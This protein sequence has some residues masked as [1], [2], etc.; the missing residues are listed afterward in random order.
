MGAMIISESRVMLRA[1]R[2]VEAEPFSDL[3]IDA[4]TKRCRH[5]YAGR[6]WRLA[7][8]IEPGSWDSP[9]C[10]FPPPVA[11][12]QHESFC[13]DQL[14]GQP[15]L[16]ELTRQTIIG[17]DGEEIQLIDIES[18][19]PWPHHVQEM[20]TFTLN[21]QC[22]IATRS[23]PEPVLTSEVEENYVWD[24]YLLSDDILGGI[25]GPRAGAIV[26]L[27]GPV[28]PDDWDAAP[29]LEIFDGSDSSDYSRRLA[30]SS[31]DDED[32]ECDASGPWMDSLD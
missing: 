9:I 32:V 22:L 28:F 20:T 8:T 1:K 30:D 19:S 15:T 14:M 4:P 21:D 23:D 10:W 24:I 26:Q 27:E 6:T 17:K 12:C 29:H 7:T 2:R 3:M 18:L 25:N 16:Y 13:A 31:S 5:D 11:S